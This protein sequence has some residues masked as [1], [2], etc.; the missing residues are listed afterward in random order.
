MIQ[1]DWFDVGVRTVGVGT[2]VYGLWDLMYAV[3]FYAGYFQNPDMT[4]RFYMIAGWFSIAI[5][6]ILIRASS[7]LVN[8]AY[9]SIE[10]EFDKDEDKFAES[11]SDKSD[12]ES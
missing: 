4:F 12:S 2:L 9:G 11:D 6:L 1:R 5:G 10:G 7:I 3:Q 8:F